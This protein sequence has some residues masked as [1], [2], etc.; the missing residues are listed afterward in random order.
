MSK[1]VLDGIRIADF[2]WAWAGPYATMLLS[3]F[4]AEVIKIESMR[5]P[6]HVRVRALAVGRFPDPNRSP[7]FNEL[8]LNKLGVRLDLTKPEA[9]EIAKRLISVSDI[10]AQNMRPG[11]MDRMGLGYDELKKIKDDIIMLSSSACGSTGHESGYIGFAPTFAALSGV[12]YL[13]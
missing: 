11:S 8:N 1:G 9:V 10:V 13:T 2:T 3:L 5:K 12:T 6:D 7:F 4:G